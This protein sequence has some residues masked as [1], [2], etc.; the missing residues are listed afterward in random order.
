[1]KKY[2][3][4]GQVS[5]IK[6]VSKKSLRYYGEL[7]ILLPIYIN[8]KTGYRYYSVEQLIIID[9]ILI[10]VNLNIPLK[11][12]KN[13]IMENGEFNIKQLIEDGK[14]IAKEKI[15][16]L[17][18][19]TFFLNK[20]SEH[21][22]RTN[23]IKKNNDSFLQYIDERYFLTCDWSKDFDDLADISRNITGLYKQCDELGIL[24]M[25]NGGIIY[26]YNKEGIDSKLFLEI[27]KFVSNVDNLL[28]VDSGDFICEVIEEVKLENHIKKHIQNK[29]YSIGSL[30]IFKQLFDC[31]VK[32][33]STLIEVQVLKL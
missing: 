10:C 13:Y 28:I 24:D 19:I 18:D 3:S 7:G 15:N 12:F 8:E 31:K 9:F 32:V 20:M 14:S 22:S 27:S 6:G 33:D 25:F 29:K 21:V 4:I 23:K 30:V 11:Q 5:K 26:K 16:K 1:M 2:L 17:N